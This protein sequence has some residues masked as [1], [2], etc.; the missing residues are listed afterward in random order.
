MPFYEYRCK[1]CETSF[2]VRRSVAEASTGVLCPSGHDEVINLISVFA[3]TGR[4]E[5]SPL[6]AC[7]S[8]APGSCGGGCACHS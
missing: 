3:P 5:A 1:T 6:T 4:V 2:E 8:A 7:G